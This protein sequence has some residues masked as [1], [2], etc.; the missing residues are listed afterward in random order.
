MENSVFGSKMSKLWVIVLST[1]VVLIMIS[2]IL[3]I[4]VFL[5]VQLAGTQKSTF[6]LINLTVADLLVGVSALFN[7]VEVI[8]YDQFIFLACHGST[9]NDA[10]LYF[11]VF[12]GIASLISL[13]LVAVERMLAILTPFRFRQAKKRHYIIGIIVSWCLALP[14]I[15]IDCDHKQKN[16]GIYFAV[17]IAIAILTMFFSYTAIYVKTK[18]FCKF[19]PTN[20]TRNNI[21]L[22][23]TMQMTTILV[24]ITWLSRFISGRLELSEKSESL[25][26]LHMG[27]IVLVYANSFVNV[28]IYTILLPKFRQQLRNMCGRRK[29]LRTNAVGQREFGKANKTFLNAHFIKNIPQTC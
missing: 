20:S 15:V 27:F 5:R 17:T 3:A 28:I 22:S 19:K 9:I 23:K 12:A 6:L 10:S 29:V 11:S 16:L 14:V 24:V 8:G 1:E 13:A 21:K 25:A 18:Y 7:V 26:N 4:K 2:N